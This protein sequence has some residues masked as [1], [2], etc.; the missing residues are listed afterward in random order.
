MYPA[1]RITTN[2]IHSSWI[3]YQDD[4]L[5]VWR[6]ERHH[7]FDLSMDLNDSDDKQLAWENCLTV[8]FNM[9]PERCYKM[10]NAYRECEC[11]VWFSILLPSESFFGSR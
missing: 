1:H 9:N 5:S 4:D 7:D 8:C 10:D 3:P 6:D 2:E 11:L